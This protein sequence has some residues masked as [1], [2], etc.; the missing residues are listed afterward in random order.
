MMQFRY[1]FNVRYNLSN[2]SQKILKSKKLY[3]QL[4]SS[5]EAI[6]QFLLDN[7]AMSKVYLKELSE[8]QEDLELMKS[9][10]VQWNLKLRNEEWYKRLLQLVKFNLLLKKSIRQ[11]ENIVKVLSRSEEPKLR[12]RAT[13]IVVQVRLGQ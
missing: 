13:D 7:Y 11:L 3:D 8:V 5:Q 10:I 6:D 1:V 4:I 9:Q 12:I 2:S